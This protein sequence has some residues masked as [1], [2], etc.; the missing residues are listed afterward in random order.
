MRSE[1]YTA[2]MADGIPLLAAVLVLG[3]SA[4]V[5]QELRRAHPVRLVVQMAVGSGLGG[6]PAA[7]IF[8]VLRYLPPELRLA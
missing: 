2:A 8:D 4:Y 3:A 6:L 7:R 1:S 5:A